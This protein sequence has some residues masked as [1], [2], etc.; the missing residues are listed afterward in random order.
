MREFLSNFSLSKFVRFT[1]LEN[2]FMALTKKKNY[3]SF[4]YQI[5]HFTRKEKRMQQIGGALIKIM[6]ELWDGAKSKYTYR[7][8]VEESKCVDP[9][10]RDWVLEELEKRRHGLKLIK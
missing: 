3:G 7:E 9:P 2:Y 8:L 4:K 5:D 1:I 6:R 10:F